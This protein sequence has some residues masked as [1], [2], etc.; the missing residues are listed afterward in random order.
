MKK[1]FFIDKEKSV[2]LKINL[3]N[4]T[5]KTQNIEQANNLIKTKLEELK[6][7]KFKEEK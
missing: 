6:I 4:K 3:E 2:S 1:A 5:Y 7:L